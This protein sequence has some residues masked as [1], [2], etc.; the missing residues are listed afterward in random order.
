MPLNSA[1]IR[2]L[3]AAGILAF[4]VA[5][6]APSLAQRPDD[7]AAN[8]NVVNDGNSPVPVFDVDAPI[9]EPIQVVSEVKGLAANAVESFSLGLVEDVPEGM[10]LEVTY[11][12]GHLISC[13]M[14]M[15]AVQSVSSA[16][17]FVNGSIHMNHE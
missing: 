5:S 16:R 6:A 15:Q 2:T 12:L 7:A 4:S 17:T 1:T 8:V 11:D 3:L 14:D 10:R 9:A 13:S